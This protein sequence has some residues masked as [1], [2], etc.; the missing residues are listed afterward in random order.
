MRWSTGIILLADG[1]QEVETVRRF[2]AVGTDYIVLLATTAQEAVSVLSCLRYTVD[3]L[4]I[5]LD[6]PDE[7]GS[8]FLRLL[9]TPGRRCA[10]KIIV[11]TSRQDES[12]LKQ[13]CCLGADAVLLKPTSAEQMVGSVHSVLSGSPNS[14]VRDLVPLPDLTVLHSSL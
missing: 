9:T 3:L 12:F 11:K 6:L 7:T 2:L 10:S 14:S 13:I 1:D 8:G 5:D 4:V